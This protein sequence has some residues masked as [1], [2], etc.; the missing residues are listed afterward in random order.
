MCHTH[1]HNAPSLQSVRVVAAGEFLMGCD[2]AQG[3]KAG[4]Y[5]TPPD[6]PKVGEGE[7]L[8]Q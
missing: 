3:L 4:R 7:G 8:C 6:P 1:L 2:P 5:L